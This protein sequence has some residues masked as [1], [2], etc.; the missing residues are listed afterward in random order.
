MRYAL[1]RA[2]QRQARALNM[3][4]DE[5]SY[6]A[7]YSAPYTDPHG[8]FN[9]RYEDYL[10]RVGDHGIHAITKE[11]QLDADEEVIELIIMARD[12]LRDTITEDLDEAI[13]ENARW[14]LAKLEEVTPQ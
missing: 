1:T 10:L 8:Y 13:K 6:A 5:A 11:R 7:S 9:R 2:A 14:V 12:A 3:D 4:P